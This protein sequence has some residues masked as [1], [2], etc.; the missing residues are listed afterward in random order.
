[1]D[2]ALKAAFSKSAVPLKAVFRKLKSALTNLALPKSA[3][4][5]LALPLN[6]ALSKLAEP[7][8]LAFPK[9]A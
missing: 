2:R 5:K 8:K 4:R 7:L 9:L 3:L 6:A 1:M